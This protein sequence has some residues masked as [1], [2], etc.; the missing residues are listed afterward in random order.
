MALDQKTNL[1]GHQA[2]EKVR[3]LLE[4]FPVACMVT[5]RDGT[6]TARPLGVVGNTSD[7]AGTLWFITDRRS[8]KVEAISAGASTSLVFENHQE[9]AYLYLTGRA[10]IVDDRAKLAQLYTEIQRTWF[11]DGLDDPNITLVRFDAEHADY[12]DGHAS[13]L[14]LALAFARATLT[15]TPGA[16]GNAGTAE[17]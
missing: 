8:R 2:L 1:D 9:G 7:F 6:A 14:R 15:G 4:H 3:A 12:W 16:S 5:V 11:P 13:W 17:F 10:A